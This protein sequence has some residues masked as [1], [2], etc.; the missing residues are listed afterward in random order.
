MIS[1]IRRKIAFSLVLVFMMSLLAGCA[2]LTNSKDRNELNST[3]AEKPETMADS[4]QAEKTEPLSAEENGEDLHDLPADSPADKENSVEYYL[5]KLKDKSFTGTYG[6]G[7]EPKVWYTAAE[8]L[9]MVGKPAIPGLIEKL[10]TDDDYERALALYALLLASQHENVKEFTN[11]EYIDVTLDFNPE[12][13]RSMVDKALA[14][15]D[16]YKDNF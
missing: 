5:E 8:E 16:K 10:E 13:H 2:T 7:E 14:W 6:D 4:S 3:S 15:W 11:G 12:T 9:G 1:G